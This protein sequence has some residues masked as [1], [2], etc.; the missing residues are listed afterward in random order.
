MNAQVH[1]QIIEMECRMLNY[2]HIITLLFGMSGLVSSETMANNEMY[3]EHDLKQEYV[4]LKKTLKDLQY[5]LSIKCNQEYKESYLIKNSNI[6][7]HLLAKKALMHSQKD[8]DNILY[9][10]ECP[11]AK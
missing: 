4:V 3:A 6:L 11:M 9:S 7:K 2:K 8:I 5:V 10:A 1:E